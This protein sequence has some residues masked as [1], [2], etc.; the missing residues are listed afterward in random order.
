[1]SEHEITHEVRDD[2]VLYHLHEDVQALVKSKGEDSQQVS[3]TLWRGMDLLSPEKGDLDS[4]AFRDKLTNLA[5]KTFGI[6]GELLSEELGWIAVRYASHAKERRR[7]VHQEHEQ[8]KPEE[9]RG[10]PYSIVDGCFVRDLSTRQ[11]M[12]ALM[13]GADPFMT[14]SNFVAE[15]VEEITVDDG[16]E[17]KRH[18]RLRG[19]SEEGISLPEVDVPADQFSGMAWVPEH[20]GV[21]ANIAAGLG[22]KDQAREAIQLYSRGA[23]QR[24]IFQHTGFRR[25]GENLIYLHGDGAVGAEGVEVELPDRLARYALPRDVADRLLPPAVRT[26]LGLLD[27][28]PDRV[29]FPLL[30]LTYLAPVSEILP[31]DFVL[32]LWG[33]TGNLKSTLAALFLSHFGDFTEDTLPL[34]FTATANYTERVLFLLKDTLT[35]V[36]DWRPAVSRGDAA[37]QDRKA[38]RLLRTVG[39]RQGR[40]R[41]RSDTSLRPTYVPRGAVIAT[42]ESIPEGPAFESATARALTVNMSR[43]E[44]DVPLLSELQSKRGELGISMYGY[45]R[46]L[47]ERYETLAADLPGLRREYRDRFTEKLP[48]GHARTS[49]TAALLMVGLSLI[50]RFAADVGA[51]TAEEGEDLMKRGEE[52]I[53]EAAR[54]HTLFTRGEDPA[55]RFFEILRSLFRAN[56]VHVKDREHGTHPDDWA[57][58]GWERRETQDVADI[59]PERGA[60]FVG[61]VDEDFL[62]LDKHAAYAAVARF[63]NRGDIPFGIRQRALWQALKRAGLTIC[64]P[65][66]PDSKPRIEGSPKWVIQIHRSI[67][68]DEG[69]E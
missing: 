45:L 10:T 11:M 59:V 18:F 16:A 60:S 34:E 58:L 35:V 46:W 8:E 50:G 68:T 27:L 13:T 43:E 23:P 20:W 38:Q 1:V 31:P 57:E 32:W 64:A 53:L 52:A 14:I 63:A 15:I 67:L 5:K 65:G 48:G 61:W 6:G 33:P 3:V 62:Y 40:G 36:D 69:G 12:S 29:T 37:E 30:A 21:I 54:A 17:A 42:A 55:T 66:R 26:S 7:E 24:F 56:E 39:N 22:T 41:M 2:G 19:V 9:L 4:S 51:I 47:P 25:R 49:G 44:V 28:A